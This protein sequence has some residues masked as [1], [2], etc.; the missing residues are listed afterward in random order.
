MPWLVYATMVLKVKPKCGMSSKLTKML[1]CFLAF[2][3]RLRPRN[4]KKWWKTTPLLT[5]L[6]VTMSR[7]AMFS[8]CL[9]GAFTQFVADVSS[10][11][12]NRLPTSPIAS[13]TTAV[14]D[15]TVSPE[16]CTR[17]WRKMPLTSRHIPTT[18]RTMWHVRTK[19]LLWWSA[20][21]SLLLSWICNN[22]SPRNWQLETLSP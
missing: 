2:L 14:W 21:T 5:S 19:T 16:S 10:Q 6:L 18:E 15:W 11:K 9:R 4:T 8:S 12:F 13:M 3:K 22:L 7:K 17:N 1:T 20:N